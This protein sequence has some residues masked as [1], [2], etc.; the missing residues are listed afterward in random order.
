MRAMY[1]V[2]MGAFLSTVSRGEISLVAETTPPDPNEEITVWVH[3]DEPLFCMELGIYVTGDAIITDAMGEA[4]CNDFGW[5]N[6][7]RSDSYIDPNGWLSIGSVRWASDAN[8]IVGYFKFRY[9]SGQV[10]V[11]ID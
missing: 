3:T 9:H 8:D 1:I 7:W 6:G 5:D 11:Y 2:L 10:A 4:D